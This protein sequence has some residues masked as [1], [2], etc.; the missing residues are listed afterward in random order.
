MISGLKPYPAYKDSG[1]KWL[2]KVPQHWGVRKQSQCVRVLVSNV[3][4]NSVE[5]E[6]PVQLC[7]YTD[8]YKNNR[9]T[10]RIPFMRATASSEEVRRFRLETGDVIITKDSESWTDIGVPSLVEYEPNNLVCGYHLAI[11]RPCE[12]VIT[13]AFLLYA[14]ESQEVMRQYHIA[15]NGVTRYGLT[16]RAIK[17]IQI[18]VPPLVDQRKIT[19]FLDYTDRHIRRYIRSRQKLISLL[20]EQKQAIIN[21]A[22]T[23]GLNPDVRLKPS[24]VECLGD[25]PEHWEVVDLRY[26]IT[27]LGS[28]ITPRGGAAVY[29]DTGIPFIRS[30][31]V[32][33]DGLEL[34]GVAHISAEL[35]RQM[36]G[37]HAKAGDVLLNI[38]GASI[39][40]V[41]AVPESLKEANVNQHVCVIR[42]RVDRVLSEYL[43]AYLSTL[44]IQSQIRIGQNG[45]S[46]EGLPL[47]VIKG[48]R[49]LLP[50]INEQQEIVRWICDNTERLS[51]AGNKAGGEITLVR[52]YYERLISDVVT[53]KLDVRE[54][55][56]QLQ[57]ESEE[58]DE[59]DWSEEV[60]DDLQIDETESAEEIPE[61]GIEPASAEP[62]HIH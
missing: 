38:T 33:F 14:S 49:I 50:S 32:R 28:G 55:A 35:H 44:Y 53:G 39:G 30:Q 15:A 24:G 12:G 54:V 40:R 4:K 26:L 48:F 18:P 57:D 16:Y 5:N 58:P 56:A 11:L 21:K 9:I 1:V 13:G 27:R 2:G 51:L 45:A 52:E 62:A 20:N 37:S 47:N 8:V 46:R 61:D 34:S 6:I 31:N 29:S 3:D 41:C 25:V 43:A 10:S 36:S 59:S 17:N 22:V 7:N 19:R 42:P 23:R 60:E